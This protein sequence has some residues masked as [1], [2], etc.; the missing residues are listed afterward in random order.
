[1]ERKAAS[2]AKLDVRWVTL[3]AS[4]MLHL[5]SRSRRIQVSVQVMNCAASIV[6]L[7]ALVSLQMKD[8]FQPRGAKKTGMWC[9][10]QRAG[11]QRVMIRPVVSLH[12]QQG[13]EGVV[14]SVS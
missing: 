7:K 14:V 8:C 5:A 6:R 2:A 11:S 3:G 4:L 9:P 12:W 10:L 13:D 1:M